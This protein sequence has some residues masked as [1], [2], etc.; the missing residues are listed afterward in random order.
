MILSNSKTW[1]GEGKKEQLHE[2][3]E[4][5]ANAMRET[6]SD[7]LYINKVFKTKGIKR[8]P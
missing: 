7:T 5:L 2:I 6:N 4:S 3:P 8:Y 1:W